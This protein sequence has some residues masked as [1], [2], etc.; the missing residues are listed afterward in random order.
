M[1]PNGLSLNS[2]AAE[3]A[4]VGMTCAARTNYLKVACKSP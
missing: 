1:H 2:K 4:M 3:I